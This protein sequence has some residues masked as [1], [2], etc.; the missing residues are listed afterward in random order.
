MASPGQSQAAPSTQPLT[1]PAEPQSNNAT[2]TTTAPSQQPS[3][4]TATAPTTTPAPASQPAQVPSTSLKDSGKSRRPRDVRLIHM[5]LASQGVTAY[6]ERVPLQLLDFA[7]RYT[8]S[9]LQDAV[10]L[11]TE[12]YAGTGPDGGGAG[13]NRGPLE[14]HSVTLPS[15]RLSIASRLHYQFQ[16]GLPK[17]FLMDVAA[18]RNRVTLPGA[19]RGFEA[20]SGKPAASNS[21]L[22]A[23][24]RLPPERFCLTGTGW[25]MSDEWDSEGEEEVVA[26]E[27]RGDAVPGGGAEEGE[28]EGDDEDGKMEDI[29]GEDAAMGDGG[30]DEDKDMTDV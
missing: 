7:Y 8:S 16:T 4:P 10:H 6:Q 15:L 18:E 19:T 17:E 29:F 20:G 3:Q 28:G 27:E 24:M 22:M 21:V 23:G 11:T 12:G 30:D 25:K 9:V 13:A 5:L 14:V 1:P 2:N 26:G